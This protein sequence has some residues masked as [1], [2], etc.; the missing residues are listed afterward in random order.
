MPL[1]LFDYPLPEELIAKYPVEPRDHARLMVLDRKNRSIRHDYFYNLP[2]Y[3]EEGDLLVLNDTKVIPARLL[4][5]KP[6]GGRVE[7]LLNRKLAEENRWL[8]LVG[9]KKI[10]PGLE[11]S[12]GDG[13]LRVRIVRQVEGPLFEV[14]LSAEGGSVMEKIYEFGKIPIPPYLERDEE[15]LDRER[16]Q[17][18]FARKEGSVAA[19][20]ASLHFT[21]RLFERL[22]K[23]GVKTA[24]VTL[25]VGLGT[26]K[27]VKAENVLDHRVDPEF[28]EVPPETVDAIKETRRRK[29][30]IVAVGTTVVRSLE[31]VASLAAEKA[32]T[33]DPS[34]VW[35]F[36]K[37]FKGFTDLYVHPLYRF[38]LVDAMITNFH[39]PKSSLLILVSAFAGRDFVLEAYREAVRRRYRF[40]SYGDAM[41]II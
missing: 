1:S 20:T 29:R 16:Y 22:R 17:T 9:G 35:K 28:V 39:L 23:K 4:G 37:P 3:L 14:E 36:L 11:V 38:K 25:H 32:K 26:F 21:E 13:S 15:P 6:T 24:F 31:T 33:E 30:R 18:V 2:E 7:V 19:P 12:V 27:P 40:Y 10:R 34:E 8:A 5:Q 41:L